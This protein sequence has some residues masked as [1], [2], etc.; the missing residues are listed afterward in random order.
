MTSRII[1]YLV[2]LHARL[3]L[4][5]IKF[6]LTKIYHLQM[7]NRILL[8]FRKLPQRNLHVNCHV[9]GT[10]F[11][12]AF[13]FQTDL[14]SLRIS[15]KCALSFKWPTAGHKV[16]PYFFIWFVSYIFF[17]DV[18]FKQSLHKEKRYRLLCP[19]SQELMFR[20]V[21]AIF[22]TPFYC[23]IWFVQILLFTKL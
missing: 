8:L 12:S 10:T 16:T 6:A 19:L 2:D 7:C 14:S 5:L 20:W 22:N 9:N 17:T 21:K 15:Y 23:L 1:Y 13:R 4:A 3:I 18:F 11:Q